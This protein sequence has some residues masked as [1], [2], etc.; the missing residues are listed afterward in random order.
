MV[1][2]LLEA[3]ETHVFAVETAKSSEVLTV[4]H[5]VDCIPL[6]ELLS[7]ITVDG[8][9]AV[10]VGQMLNSSLPVG[11]SLFANVADVGV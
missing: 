10:C 7:A 5:V 4:L 9:V 11:V 3:L 2:G 6:V 8:R 1:V